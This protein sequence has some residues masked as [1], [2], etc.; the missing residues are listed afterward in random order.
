[1][2]KKTKEETKKTSGL[3]PVF[4]ALAGNAIITVLKFCGFLV[5]GSG[6][7]FSEAVHSFADTAN[8][9]L[10][11]VGIKKSMKQADDEY[12]YGYGQERFLWALISACGI[13][14]LGAGVTIYHGISTLIHGKEIHLD[15]TIFI[16]LIISFAV[17]FCTFIMAI[18]ELRHSRK[19][20]FWD[21]LKNGDPATLAV[22]YE[23]GVAVLGI[24]LGV[25][26]II[27]INKNRT[28]LIGKNI[29]EEMKERIIEIMEADP[30]IEKVLDFKSSILDIGQYQIKCEVEF[31]GN[32]LIRE[33]C[34]NRSLKQEFEEVRHDYDE[35]LRFCVDYVDRVPRLVGSKIDEIESRIK[36]EIPEM[37]HIDIE[38]N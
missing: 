27:L 35:F 7:M 24:L 20:D 4:F 31:N 13:F 11:L 9:G 19:G 36:K 8:Q 15:I 28:Y 1:M 12:S 6:A 22:V 10:L 14:F 3:V 17:E 21:S 25:V 30:T 37:R 26:A 16:I 33:L 38:I 18:Q 32:F 34:K 2:S 23:D 29:P 5:S